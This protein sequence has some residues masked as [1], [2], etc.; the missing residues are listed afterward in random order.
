MFCYI[1]RPRYLMFVPSYRDIDFD[2]E[3]D[4]FRCLHGMGTSSAPVGKDV[5]R[6]TEIFDNPVFFPADGSPNS[7]SI[8]QG[9]LGD[10]YFLSALATVSSLPG[11]IEKICVAVCL[12]TWRGA[13][14]SNIRSHSA[15]YRSRSVW[16][17]LLPGSR[18]GWCDSGRVSVIIR[19]LQL[20]QCIYSSWLM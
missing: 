1:Q 16:F 6:V 13:S 5:Q 9:A 7:S 18:V 2:L 15:R 4:Q 11:L 12:Q 3:F 20:R 17:Y 14:Y 19:T 8:R 10:C